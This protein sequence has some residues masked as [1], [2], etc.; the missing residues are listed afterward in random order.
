MKTLILTC[1]ILILTSITA[2]AQDTLYLDSKNQVV[3]KRKQADQFKVIIN[4]DTGYVVEILTKNMGLQ[5]RMT[6]KDS[7]L[8]VLHGY[9]T[10]YMGN[11]VFTEGRYKDGKRDGLWAYNYNGRRT[12][13]V[14]YAN[15]IIIN[16]NYYKADG[17][18]ETDIAKIEQLPSFI[19]GP[20]AM[21][22]YLSRTLKYPKAARDAR[23]SGTVQLE[24]TVM[25]NGQISDVDVIKQ[26]N[27][28]IDSEAVRVVRQMPRWNPGVQFGRPVRV[29]YKM[30]VSFR[31][32][33]TLIP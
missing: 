32:D 30:P 31:L 33:T 28:D 11:A 22:E 24:F 26:V 3:K 27:S 17:T 13:D 2:L 25:P 1:L 23:I 9:F 4:T 10:E 7:Q 19:G 14:V 18:P 16:A 5:R 12:A 20:K 29:R 6:Y 15:D 8:K 21:H